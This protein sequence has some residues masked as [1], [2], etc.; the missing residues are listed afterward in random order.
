MIWRSASALALMLSFSAGGHVHAQT[1]EVISSAEKQ[2][3]ADLDRAVADGRIPGAIAIIVK[4]DRRLADVTVGYSDVAAKEPLRHDAIFRLYSMSKPVTSVAIMMLAERGKLRLDDPVAKYL[5]EWRDMR[6][7]ASGGLDDMVTEPVRRPVTIADLLTHSGG[8]TY[9]FTGETPVHQYYRKYGV[10]RDTPVGRMPG[11]GA[12]ARTLDELVAR[13]GRAPMLHQPGETFAY[14]YSTTVLGAVIERASGQ[15]LDRFLKEQLFDPLGMKDT[16]FFVAAA[17]LGRFTPLYRE[18]AEGLAVAETAAASDYRDK[19]RLLD[20]GGAIAGTAEDYLRFAEMLANDGALGGTRIL[21]K[22][23]VDAMLT[24]RVTLSGFGPESLQFGYGFS[25]GD[26]ASAARG[27]L[28]AGAASWA[29]SGNTWFFVDREHRAAA[30]V[31]T[32][33]LGSGEGQAAIRAAV[34][35]AFSQMV[36]D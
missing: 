28:P 3:R 35:S 4:G 11:D 10:M 7:Y 8:I 29:G 18:T 31:M 19:A 27:G 15:K 6:V 1:T 14:S 33:F 20:G 22:A 12:P 25:L 26:A 17:D 30:L 16:G 21:S 9:H 34:G 32:H 23:S 2:L 24:P 13:L 36:R 5:P